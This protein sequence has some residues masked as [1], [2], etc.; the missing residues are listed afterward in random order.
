MS[1][2]IMPTTGVFES[3]KKLTDRPVIKQETSRQS[4]IASLANSD[5]FKALQEVID[6]W[7]QHLEDIP[8]D[9]AKDDV[10][11]VGFRYLAS[12]VT[13]EYLTDLRNMPARY[14]ELLKKDE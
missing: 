9:P 12:K 8:V 13:K 2:A 5:A 3:F 7:I 6:Q 1:E 4:K 10:T 14:K 11:S